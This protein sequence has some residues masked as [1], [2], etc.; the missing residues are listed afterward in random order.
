MIP[1]EYIELEKYNEVGQEILLKKFFR[2]ALNE[3]VTKAYYI[4]F[5]VMDCEYL[6][7]QMY[8]MFCE[9]KD[10]QM[11]WRRV[12]KNNLSHVFLTLMRSEEK[13]IIAEKEIKE[14]NLN[15]TKVLECI[16]E[17]YQYITLKDMAKDFHFHENY[18]SRII[19]ENSHKSFREI[20]CD[21][22]L[23]ESEKL[24]INTEL[25]VTEIASKIGYLKPNF[26]FKLFKDHY[27]VTPMEYR[28]LYSV[29]NQ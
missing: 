8:N 20:L 12:V 28:S 4:V 7:E 16:R 26:F 14:E 10:K 3:N 27:G 18:L 23:K 1:F 9:Y 22:R 2:H 15:I 29:S 24:L 11:G 5:S 13:D 17:N 25:S 6:E 21:T 19:K